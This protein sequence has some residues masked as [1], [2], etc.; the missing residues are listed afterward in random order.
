MTPN[1]TE[2]LPREQIEARQLEKL[3]A[4]LAE[5]DGRNP[6]WTAKFAAAGFDASG[7]RLLEDFRR[8]PLT[9]K[10]ELVDDQ[11]AHPHPLVNDLLLKHARS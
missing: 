1:L 9:T 11:N 7:V 8:L 6:F 4:L 3:R 2:R 10:Q 5:L